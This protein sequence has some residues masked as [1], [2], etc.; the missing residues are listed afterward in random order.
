MLSNNYWDICVCD[1][2]EKVV[3]RFAA[4]AIP[5][6]GELINFPQF[7]TFKVLNVAYRFTDNAPLP[8]LVD[9]LMYVELIV[10]WQHPVKCLSE[11]L[12]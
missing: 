7:G 10:D 4:S 9:N 6:K 12:E 3:C 11:E 8:M 1:K 5:H 2:E